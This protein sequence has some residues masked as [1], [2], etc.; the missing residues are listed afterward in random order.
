MFNDISRLDK[1]FQNRINFSPTTQIIAI[2]QLLKAFLY[3]KSDSG[4]SVSQKASY[5]HFENFFYLEN[6]STFAEIW[7]ISSGVTRQHPPIHRKPMSNHSSM[8]SAIFVLNNSQK[9][10]SLITFTFVHTIVRRRQSI[11][12][13]SWYSNLHPNWDRLP[14]SNLGAFSW[15][16]YRNQPHKLVW[17]N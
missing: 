5:K 8:K 17:Y 13:P 3:R 1:R 6:F 11:L 10:V 4:I 2:N 15:L 16:I 14:T 7:R 12:R 9:C